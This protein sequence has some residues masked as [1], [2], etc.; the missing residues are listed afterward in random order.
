VYARKLVEL[1]RSNAVYALEQA[2]KLAARDAGHGM[3]A[4]AQVQKALSLPTLPR[5]I[6]CFDISNM[7]GEAAVA[8]R[9]T[10]IDGAPDKNLY[11][12]YKIKTVTGQNDFA[13]MKEV[14]ERRLTGSEALP[15]LIVVDGG[16]G[17]LAQAVAILGELGLAV[18]VVGLAKARTEKDF[19]SSVVE[20]SAER[21]FIPGRV[22]PIPLAA[23]TPAYRLLVHARDEAHRFA[24][25]YHRLQRDRA[26]QGTG[27]T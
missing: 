18:P 19:Q 25:Q 15:D 6:E 5:R 8:S 2:G 4:V 14:L 17:Q 20:S 16:R 24:I 12:R 11:R 27:K 9:V 1:A 13:M 10:F 7:Q 22:N 26:R 3:E 21:I 23:H